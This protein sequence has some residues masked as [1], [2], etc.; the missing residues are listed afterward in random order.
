MVSFNQVIQ[1]Y[2]LR[3]ITAGLAAVLSSDRNASSGGR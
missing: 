1:L 2:G 3:F